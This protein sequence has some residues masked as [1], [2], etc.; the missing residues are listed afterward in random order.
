VV[1]AIPRQ[2]GTSAVEVVGTILRLLPTFQKEIPESVHLTTLYDRSIT[3]RAEPGRALVP[4][5][6]LK[7]QP[8]PPITVTG[9]DDSST[10]PWA[11]E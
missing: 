9:T 1:L 5:E 11:S 8:N 6:I 10:P 3:L 7:T 2:P 4:Q